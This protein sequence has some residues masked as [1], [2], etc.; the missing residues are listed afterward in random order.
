MLLASDRIV[1]LRAAGVSLV[2]DLRPPVPVVLHWG[3]DLGALSESAKE[4]LSA[5]RGTAQLN[6]A[7]DEPREFSLLPTE[8][9]GW[10]GVPAIAGHRA[11]AATTP[12]ND[13]CP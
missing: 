4:A 5:T 9:E 1:N 10:S 3:A 11:G 8:F 7:P 6:N 12:V 2:I 13:S